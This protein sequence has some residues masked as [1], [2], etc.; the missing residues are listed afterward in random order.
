MLRDVTAII[1]SCS[2]NSFLINHSQENNFQFSFTINFFFSEKILV[3]KLDQSGL[4]DFQG[5]LGRFINEY[6]ENKISYDHF[7]LTHTHIKVEWD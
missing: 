1:S 7:T 6:F 4:Y 3:K 5:L 2:S